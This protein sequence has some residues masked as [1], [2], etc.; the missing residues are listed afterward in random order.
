MN[1]IIGQTLGGYQILEQIGKGGMGT[2]FKAYQPSLE[3]HV[4]VKILPPYFAAQDETFVKRFRQ[5]A[6][7]VAKLRHPNILVVMDH[8]EQQGM[9]YL[10]MEY[11]DAGT[12]HEM[13]GA[14]MSA[15]EIAPIISQ[16]ASALDYAHG[17]GVVHRDIKPSNILLPKPDWPLLTDFGLAKIVGATQLTQSGTI[18]GTPAYMSPEQGRGDR[19]DARSDI[20]SLGVVLYEMATGSVPYEAETPMAV[21]VKHIIEPLPLP[22]SRNPDLPESIERV[23]LK[24]LAKDP[25]DRYQ[26]ASDFGEALIAAVGALDA[27]QRVR[28]ASPAEAATLVEPS[29]PLPVGGEQ[30]RETPGQ[31]PAAGAA[32][33]ALGRSPLAVPGRKRRALLIGSLGVIGLAAV[34]FGAWQLG[35]TGASPDAPGAAVTSASPLDEPPP[36]QAPPDQP[37]GEFDPRTVEQLLADGRAKVEAG[38]PAGALLEF[39]AAHAKVPGSTEVMFELAGARYWAGDPEGAMASIAQAQESAPED[40][41]VQ[42][43][44]GWLLK[45]LDFFPQA[46]EAFERALALNPAALWIYDSLAKL[47]FELGAP[48]SAIH[49]LERAL[50]EGVEQDPGLLESLGWVFTEWG[51]PDQGEALFT[52]LADR[53]PGNPAGPKGLAEIQYRRGDLGGAIENLSSV[54]AALPDVDGHTTLAWWLWEAGDTAAARESFQ[55]AIA[56]DPPNAIGAYEG[57]TSLLLEQGETAEAEEMLRQA[58]QAFPEQGELQ[59][60]LGDLLAWSLG[61][62]EEALPLYQAAVDLDPGNGWRHLDLAKLHVVL[63][64]PEPAV[65]LLQQAA[66]LGPDDPWLADGIGYAYIDLGMCEVAVEHFQRALALDSSIT[67]SAEGIQACGG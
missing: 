1:G 10:V 45:E 55:Q 2:V 52:S 61:R 6:R 15:H 31:T 30:A 36:D 51:M 22:R 48:E 21:V 16:V 13:L 65:M 3:R 42:E 46:A 25:A 12:L 34:A 5:E 47:Y 4:A 17:Q 26:R 38:D 11:V 20:Y 67:S 49:T 66:A 41:D 60:E 59:V 53:Y 8:G 19:I 29:R 9:T 63:G 24:A 23:L 44:A 18:A 62:P 50:A 32:V 35:R 33:P 14:P 56:L 43:S 7:A 28:V 37:G 58:V 40:A 64:R 27:E 57:L 54:V 39:E